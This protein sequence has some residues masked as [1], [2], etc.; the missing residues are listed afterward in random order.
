MERKEV[1]LKFML[2]LVIITSAL[3][4]TLVILIFIFY[5]NE[6]DHDEQSSDTSRFYEVLEL[7]DTR[8][9]GNYD[10]EQIIDAAIRAAVDSLDDQW[11]HFMNQAEY[12]AFLETADNTYAGIGVTVDSDYEIGGMR[13]TGVHRDSG[14]YT[15]GIII[16]D[17]I[18]AIDGESIAGISIADIRLS[19]RRP[20]GDT[21]NLTVFRADG[22]FH[23]MTVIYSIVFIDPVSYEMLEGY[24]GYVQL[25]N[26]DVGSADS[27]I[28]AVNNLIEQGAV[29]F[30]FDVR[31]NNGG[32]VN[33]ITQILDFLLP[34]GDIFISINR[35]GV[36]NITV[37]DEYMIDLPAVVL[38]NSNSFSGAE[39]FA[40]MLSEFEY[41]YT[42]GE[43]T[44]GKNRMQTTIALDNGGAVVLSTG[45]YLTRNRVS[46][47]DVGGFTPDFIIPLTAEQYRDALTLGPDAGIDPQLEKAIY[48][49]T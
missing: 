18:T 2:T 6:Y 27:F 32:R 13:V 25:R 29:A 38:V 22:E 8:F 49:L 28:I 20:I 24:I 47:F 48:L 4:A 30:I 11:S 16:G 44:T 15:A 45:E 33:E 36:E 5:G 43:P 12:E 17:V 40:A 21:V 26:F 10:L 46:L 23:E 31:S 35:T 7:I 41:A 42:V 14:A 37:S 39:F 3:T 9:I 34:E 19:L 1:S